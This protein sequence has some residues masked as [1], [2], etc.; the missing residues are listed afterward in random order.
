M[1]KLLR[2]KAFQ[3]TAVL[4]MNFDLESLTTQKLIMQFATYDEQLYCW[5]S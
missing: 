5:F 2:F 1:T 4:T 3:Y